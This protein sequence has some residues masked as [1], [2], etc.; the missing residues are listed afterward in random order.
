MDGMTVA[1]TEYDRELQARRDAEAEVIRLRVLLSNL[2]L[3][4]ISGETKKQEVQKQLSKE[5]TDSLSNLEKSLSK[6]KVE[7]DMTIA[8]VEQLSASKRFGSLPLLT[9]DRAED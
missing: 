5:L 8:E 9:L 3:T 1:Q 4:A 2:R 7:R 6:L